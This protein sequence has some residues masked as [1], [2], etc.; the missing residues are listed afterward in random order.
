[1]EEALKPPRKRSLV[2]NLIVGFIALVGGLVLLVLG[3][4]D[5]LRQP[6]LLQL[7]LALVLF[8]VVALFSYQ[9]FLVLTTRFQLTRSAL[10]LQWGFRREVLPLEQVEWAHPVLDFDSPMPLPGFV[11]PFQ[12]YGIRRIRGLGTVEFAATDRRNMVLIRAD[13]R[14]FVISPEDAYAFASE[15]EKLSALG[16]QEVVAPLSQTGRNLI[17]EILQDSMARKLF[18]A[19]IVGLLTLTAVSIALSATRPT[20]TWITLELVPSNRLLLL[21]LVGGL[22]WLLNTFLGGYFYLRGLLEKRWIF[23]IW[24]WSAFMSLT[25]SAAAVFMSV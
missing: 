20:I 5:A 22:D 21:L 11:L 10:E 15:F 17:G 1:M 23:L 4:G 19:G 18:T 6:N 25:L 3:S 24:S 9:T 2:L 12:Y 8:V 13:N 7:T 16:P 14:H